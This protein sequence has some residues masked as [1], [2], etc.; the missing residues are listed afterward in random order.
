MWAATNL[1]AYGGRDGRSVFRHVQHVCAAQPPSLTF[2]DVDDGHAQKRTLPNTDAG[3]ADK[4]FGVQQEMEKIVWLHVLKESELLGFHHLTERAD[5][6]CRPFR[7]RVR[8][9]PKTEDRH[10]DIVN[11]V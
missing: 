9:W 10:S 4:A 6:F 8:I 11:R 1:R 5:R 7:T 2:P 3:V